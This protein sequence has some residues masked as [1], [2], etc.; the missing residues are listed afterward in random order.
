[1]DRSR[2]PLTAVRARIGSAVEREAQSTSRRHVIVFALDGIACRVAQEAWGHAVIE[3]MSSVFPTTS[4]TCWLS[5]LT[6]LSVDRHG[7]PG[8]VFRTGDDGGDPINVFAH[9]GELG[10]VVTGNV[11]SDAARLGYLPVSLAGDLDDYDCAWREMLLR[12]SR[13]VRGPRVYAPTHAAEPLASP[14]ELCERIRRSIVGLLDS[15]GR[16][17]SLFVWCFADVDRHVHRHGYDDH[18]GEFLRGIE[19]LAIDLVAEGCLRSWPDPN[20]SRSCARGRSQGP[21]QTPRLG[22]RGRGPLPLALR[23]GAGWAGDGAR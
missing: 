4:S 17:S 7:V 19:R 11:F 18:V 6:G 12:H 14:G 2:P 20:R 3:E 21:D 15:D 1:L 13:R 23:G 10:D 9:S 5:S 22:D 8:V 16:T